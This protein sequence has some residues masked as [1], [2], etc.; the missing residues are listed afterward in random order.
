MQ[1]FVVI[2]ALDVQYGEGGARV[3]GVGFRAWTDAAPAFER[4]VNVAGA[5]AAYEPGKFYLRELPCLLALLRALPALPDTCVVDGYVAL[6]G[7][8]PGLGARLVDALGDRVTVVGVAKN[9]FHGAFAARVL[10]GASTKPLFVTATGIPLAEAARA[11]RAMYGAHRIPTL[12]A[13][14][15]RLSRGESLR[16]TMPR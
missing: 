8:R 15:D 14:A 2:V 7:G 10:R 12:L 6:A 16:G 4:V 1:S 13:R 11:V 3:A 5:A 9:E